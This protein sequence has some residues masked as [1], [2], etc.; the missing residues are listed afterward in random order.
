MRRWFALLAGI[1]LL[2][3]LCACGGAQTPAS[4]SSQGAP[5]SADFVSEPENRSVG[6]C[7]GLTS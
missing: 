3:A 2:L 5:A 6:L 1:E 4:G 7:I